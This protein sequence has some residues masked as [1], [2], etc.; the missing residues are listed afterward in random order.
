MEVPFRPYINLK[1]LSNGVQFERR[2]IQ[3]NLASRHI[4]FLRVKSNW[5]TSQNCTLQYYSGIN[6]ELP[7]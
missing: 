1:N 3:G 7:F 5:M 2:I 6:F 4:F